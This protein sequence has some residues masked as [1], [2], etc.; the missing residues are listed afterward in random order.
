MS[1]KDTI[2]T[3]ILTQRTYQPES[4]LYKNTYKAL[5]KLSTE[6]LSG[7]KVLMDMKVADA[8]WTDEELNRPV[9]KE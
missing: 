4:G 6:Q 3:Q 2:I 5:E 1:P 8:L 9:V 7:L